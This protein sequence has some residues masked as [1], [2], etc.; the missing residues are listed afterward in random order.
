[1]RSRVLL[2]QGLNALCKFLTS[3]ILKSV[4]RYLYGESHLNSS[5]QLF[6]NLITYNIDKEFNFIYL[7]K[8]AS[9]HLAVLHAD[10]LLMGCFCSSPLGLMVRLLRMRAL[11][12]AR[13]PESSHMCFALVHLY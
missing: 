9:P 4:I 1:M 11:Q 12:L 7:L 5:F 2:S 6:T 13:C 3:T 8:S 10:V